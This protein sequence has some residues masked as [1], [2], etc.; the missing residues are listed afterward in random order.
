[1]KNALYKFILLL[2]LIWSLSIK[3]QQQYNYE[4]FGGIIASEQTIKA[5]NQ[6]FNLK[7]IMTPILGVGVYKDIFSAMDRKNDE[8]RIVDVSLNIRL[9]LKGEGVVY[10]SSNDSLNVKNQNMVYYFG[11]APSLVIRFPK[12]GL[13]WG[14]GLNMD[15]V[16]SSSSFVNDSEVPGLNDYNSLVTGYSSRMGFFFGESLFL[17]AEIYRSITKTYD[18]QN[19]TI[20][21]N[22]WNLKIG[23]KF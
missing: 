5:L 21:D 12:I 10:Y 20:T 1:M 8:K 9:Y 15:K 22:N 4:I 3:A 13:Y 2:F 11:I 19:I 18:L 6:N 23:F 17:E 14:V 7:R 16:I